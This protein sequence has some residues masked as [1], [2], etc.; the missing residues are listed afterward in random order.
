M[1]SVVPHSTANVN[2][3]DPVTVASPRPWRLSRRSKRSS[4]TSHCRPG[5]WITIMKGCSSPRLEVPS[6]LGM[7]L[8][9]EVPE[10]LDATS[11]RRWEPTDVL[12]G[13]HS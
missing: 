3:A 9:H 2:Q 6:L 7:E 11:G 4:D 5:Q 13:T 10:L 8:S 1:R 12:H